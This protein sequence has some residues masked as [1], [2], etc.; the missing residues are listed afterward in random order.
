MKKNNHEVGRA[1]LR[2]LSQLGRESRA[3]KLECFW[4]RCA[5][6][7]W[8][9][10]E[11]RL[12]WILTWL[13]H[14]PKESHENWLRSIAEAYSRL[15]GI[16]VTIETEPPSQDGSKPGFKIIHTKEPHKWGVSDLDGHRTIDYSD[17]TFLK[18]WELY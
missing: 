11:Q 13:F 8:Q 18:D 1:C 5:L 7:P 2:A 15:H 17:F 16:K 6:E 9:H 10:A 4:S 14:A 3:A 12:G